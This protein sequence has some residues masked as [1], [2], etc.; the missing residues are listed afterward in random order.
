MQLIFIPAIFLIM[1]FLL[2][3]PQRKRQMEATQLRS[4]TAVGDEILTTSGIYGIV[5]AMDDEDIWLEVSE[6]N[7][8]R[9]A[10]GAILRITQSVDQPEL[11]DLPE[12]PEHT[13]AADSESEPEA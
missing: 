4:R 2:I 1:Y 7:E 13:E 9:M 6:N 8:I 3:R 11:D 10:R 5:T 12:L